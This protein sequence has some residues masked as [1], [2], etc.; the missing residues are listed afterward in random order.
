[1]EPGRRRRDRA[2]ITGIDRL[3][4]FAVP[5]VGAA[6]AADIRGQGRPPETLDRLPERG[7]FEAEFEADLAFGA[8]GGDVGPK[9]GREIDPVAGTQPARSLGEGPPRPRPVLFMERH[10]D[11]GLPALAAKARRDH[12]GVVQH[13]HVARPE[14]AGQ[15]ADGMIAQTLTHLEQARTIPRRHGPAGDHLARQV[16]IEIRDFHR[17]SEHRQ[18]RYR[19]S[20]YRR[21]VI[22]MPAP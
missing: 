12:L 18:S 7:A 3:V 9:A 1:M 13:H 8:L 5:G 17:R 16:E 22:V 19:R 11:R 21:Q 14:E 15:V 10:L 2:F 6:G 20:G 4:V